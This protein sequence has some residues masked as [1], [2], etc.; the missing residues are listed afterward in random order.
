MSHRIEYVEPIRQRRPRIKEPKHLDLIRQLPCVVCNTMPVE[1]AH[2][3]SGSPRHGKRYVGVAEKSDDK[4]TLPLCPK[5]HRA[6]HA[7]NEL[8][9]WQ[10]HNIDPF[11]TALALWAAEGDIATMIWITCEAR[12]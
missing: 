6:Q 2:I 10:L 1:A 4:W 9:F 11:A 7:M 8:K 5:H 3:R 12:L